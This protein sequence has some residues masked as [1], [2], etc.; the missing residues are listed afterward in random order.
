RH[1]AR[2]GGIASRDLSDLLPVDD[3]D[4]TGTS[5]LH[6]RSGWG[7]AAGRRGR[8]GTLDRIGAAWGRRAS[9]NGVDGVTMPGDL[10][11]RLAA[12]LRV[13][14]LG[15][16]LA[17]P[18]QATGP[19]YPDAQVYEVPADFAGEWIGEVGGNTGLL[20]I[21]LLGPSRYRGVFRGEG[22]VAEYVLAMDQRTAPARDG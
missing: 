22:I 5:A 19:V 1:P 16:L 4:L 10:R 21:D 7:G 12:V 3:R 14:A 17:C 6:G 15:I 20:R 8:G 18:R 13:A 2:D 11:P 9:V